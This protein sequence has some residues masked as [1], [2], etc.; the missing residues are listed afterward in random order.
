[1]LPG[2][3]VGAAISAVIMLGASPIAGWF[4]WP[5][6]W[7]ALIRFWLILAGWL[8]AGV[9][10]TY[11]AASFVYRLTPRGLHVDFGMMYRPV[12]VV[13]LKEVTDVECRAWVL[14][15]LFGVGSV[16]VRTGKGSDVRMRGILHPE[17][18]ADA[19]RAAV[20]KA[21]MG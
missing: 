10:W 15:R 12:P 16:I 14:R 21:R 7:T 4:D 17:R 9:I 5:K 13:P 20:A 3:V 11:R 8:V 18:F 1:M 19:I 6:D 2:L